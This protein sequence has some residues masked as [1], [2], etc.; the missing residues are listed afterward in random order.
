[1]IQITNL[2]GFF[3]ERN[4][5]GTI[6]IGDIALTKSM[7]K[8]MEEIKNINKITSGFETCISARLLQS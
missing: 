8:Y 7:P 6:C 3:C 4:V 1:M 5:H 2:T